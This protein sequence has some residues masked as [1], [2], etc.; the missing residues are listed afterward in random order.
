MVTFPPFQYFTLTIFRVI[1]ITVIR[2]VLLKSYFASSDMIFD[3]IASGIA[4]QCLLGIT[5][6]TACIPS[7][8]PFLDGFESG[9]L[10]VNFKPQGGTFN[11]NNYEMHV[12]NSSNRSASRSRNIDVKDNT[13][14]YLAAIS[15]Q[16]SR[17]SPGETG[18][19]D[20]RKSDAMIIKRTDHWDIRYE[21]SH[22]PSL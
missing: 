22:V 1:V 13:G 6:L 10:G 4:S 9:M 3:S 14:A 19:V 18:S 8:K 5:I 11:G 7:L 2:I 21:T 15:S 12:S 20:S 17:S 16:R